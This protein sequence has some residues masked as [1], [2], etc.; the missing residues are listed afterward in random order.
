MR[1]ERTP[2][3]REVGSSTLPRPTRYR[4]RRG[5]WDVV[6]FEFRSLVFDVRWG[7]SSAGRA[8]ALHAGGHRFE[9]VHL[10]Q[11]E[12]WWVAAR[13]CGEVIDSWQ[14]LATG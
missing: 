6:F 12:G 1:L 5:E 8:P 10:H 4:S 13:D 7:C 11:G 2:D 14:L 9:S 3:K